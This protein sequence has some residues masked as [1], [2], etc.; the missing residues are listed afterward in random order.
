MFCICT[1]TRCFLSSSGCMPSEVVTAHPACARWSASTPTQTGQRQSLGGGVF[2]WQEL[3]TFSWFISCLVLPLGKHL[4]FWGYLSADQKIPLILRMLDHSQAAS[5]YKV[6]FL[7]C[8]GGSVWW[9]MIDLMSF[10]I[11]LLCFFSWSAFTGGLVVLPWRRGVEVWE[12]PRGTAFCTPLEVTMLRRRRLH[13]G[14]VTVWKGE[15]TFLGFFCFCLFFLTN[16]QSCKGR[17][18][19]APFS[20]HH[21][22]LED[23]KFSV[24]H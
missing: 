10:H 9:V 24:M 19:P 20:Q 11:H 12:W 15:A 23:L 18:L 7:M 8:A 3:I 14:W 16:K 22:L 17:A 13:L 5:G 4:F 21:Q 2:I 1:S 6:L